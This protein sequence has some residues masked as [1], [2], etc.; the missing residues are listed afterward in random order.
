[1]N[2]PDRI[3]SPL[4][5]LYGIRDPEKAKEVLEHKILQM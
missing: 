2:P 4:D 5:C 3:H 1:V